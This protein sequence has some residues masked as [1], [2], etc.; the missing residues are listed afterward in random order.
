MNNLHNTK[1]LTIGLLVF[2]T[3]G[4]NSSYAYCYYVDCS[5]VVTSYLEKYQTRSTKAFTKLTE[6][7]NTLQ[8]KYETYVEELDNFI[9][10]QKAEVKLKSKIIVELK[11]KE[12]IQ[13]SR[14]KMYFFIEKN[15][16]LKQGLKP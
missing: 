9:E 3:I 5:T 16:G 4:S 12:L 14:I 6:E 11:K 7:K 1:K 13:S 2:F 15:T 8:K 10:L